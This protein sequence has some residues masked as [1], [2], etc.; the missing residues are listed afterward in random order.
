MNLFDR[1]V[2][3]ATGLVAIYLL[4]RFY[5]GSQRAAGVRKQNTY[6][7]VSFAVL[8]VAGL[9]LIAFGYDALASPLVVIVGALIPLGIALGLITEFYPQ[10]E[11]AYLVFALVGVVAIAIT[12]FV[13]PAG[14]A[15]VVLVIFH[16]ISGVIILGLPLLEVS[17]DRA[18]G[19]FALVA[20][21][22][23]LIDV[24]GVALAFLKSGS[25]LLFFSETVVFA[26]LAPLLL[27]MTLAFTWGFMKNMVAKQKA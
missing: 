13:G 15:T 6:Y 25:Q 21:G 5:E 16:A 7:M 10:F 8:L 23:L 17:Q 3:L 4:F 27:L 14:F 9:L 19:G 1:L 24:G 2:L 12:R 26:I 22:G 18:P 20:V 11:K